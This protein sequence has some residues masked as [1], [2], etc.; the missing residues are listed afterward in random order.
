[1]SKE[2]A[3]SLCGI[4]EELARSVYLNRKDSVRVYSGISEE[5][6]REWAGVRSEHI[7]IEELQR[8]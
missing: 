1:M 6:F 7:M 5:L 8:N 4:S 3:R 2:S